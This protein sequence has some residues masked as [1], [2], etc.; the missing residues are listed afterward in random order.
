[1]SDFITTPRQLG[2]SLRRQRKKKGLTQGQ[3]SARIGKRQATI[4]TLE[5][6]GSGTL[7]T[8]FTVLSALDLELTM[9][10]RM[11]TSKARLEDIF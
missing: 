10:P 8:L 6:L 1:M 7:E 2:S 4:S 9:R 5:S 3:L 11:K